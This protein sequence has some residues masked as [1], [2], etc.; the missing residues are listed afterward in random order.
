M[1]NNLSIIIPSRNRTADLNRQIDYIKNWGAQILDG[2]DKINT[3]IHNLSIAEPQ[4]KYIHNTRGFNSRMIFLKGRIKTK[5]TMFMGDDEFFVKNSLKKFIQFLENNIDY[6]SCSGVAVAFKKTYKKVLFK[7]IYSRLIG[8]NISDK[9]PKDRVVR[10][11][12]KYVCSS[13]YGINRTSTF[14]KFI[15]QFKHA[16]TSCPETGE[17]WF[18]SL[19]AL[20]GKIMVLPILFWFRSFN[21]EPVQDIGWN[22]AIKFFYWYNKNKFKIEKIKFI[23][24]FCKLNKE[25]SCNF[26]EL[27]LLNYTTDLKLMGHGSLKY[28]QIIIKFKE[29]IKFFLVKLKLYEKI[30]K[31]D[32]K[33]YFDY[34]SLK[35]YLKKK[36]ILYDITSIKKINKLIQ[37]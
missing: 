1:L 37:Q 7:E 23:K 35:S 8:Y 16:T 28:L 24:S 6:A 34:K 13:I 10:H 30:N 9:N 26:F 29:I 14:D 22:R 32:D 31:I 11:L 27:A 17:I 18:E 4:I 12:S 15:S 36:K 2:S 33:S 19:T 21:N 20:R 3:Y 25:K 5:Y